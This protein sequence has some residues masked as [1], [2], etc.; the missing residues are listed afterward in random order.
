MCGQLPSKHE[1]LRANRGTLRVIDK[2]GSWIASRHNST[3]ERPL[4][5]CEY[6]PVCWVERMIS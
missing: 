3:P 2:E 1:Y 5:A 4:V 6:L